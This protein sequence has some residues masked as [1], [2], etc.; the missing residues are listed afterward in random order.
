[1]AYPRDSLVRAKPRTMVLLFH[2]YAAS[3]E[4]MLPVARVLHDLG[5]D[6]LL[7]DFRGCGGSTGDETTV[8]YREADDVITA[9]SSRE[10]I[11]RLSESSCWAIQWA[12]PPCCGRRRWIRKSRTLIVDAPFDRLLS[13]VENRFTAMRLPS[14]PFARLIVFWGGTRQGYWAFAHNPADYASKITCPVLHLH[15]ENASAR[16]AAAG[17]GV[18]QQPHGIEVIRAVSSRVTLRIWKPIAIC[19]RNRFRNF[20]YPRQR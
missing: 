20:C 10:N 11:L 19:G 13:T 8:G 9:R 15:G 14:F 4:M 5:Y 16:D 3:K 7:V 2:A 12:P 17:T 6:T 1:M 18:V